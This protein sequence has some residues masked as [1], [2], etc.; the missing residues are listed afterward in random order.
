MDGH[1]VGH[2]HMGACIGQNDS[3][4]ITHGQESSEEHWKASNR[5]LWCVSAALGDCVHGSSSTA[6]STAIQRKKLLYW[7]I[8]RPRPVPRP[9]WSNTAIYSNTAQCSIQ[10][11]IA[12][13]S[14]TLYNPPLPSTRRTSVGH[15]RFPQGSMDGLRGP[16]CAVGLTSASGGTPCRHA[17]HTVRYFHR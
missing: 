4:H 6:H 10:Q 15:N 16:T 12:L 5:H 17:K 1:D 13:Q 7:P 9:L 11:Y 14:T 2:G 8:Q 3:P